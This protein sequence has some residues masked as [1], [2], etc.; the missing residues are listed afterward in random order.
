[1]NYSTARGNVSTLFAVEINFSSCGTPISIQ[2]TQTGV[3]VR[4]Q[5]VRKAEKND[6]KGEN[7]SESLVKRG[8]N[9]YNKED[10]IA[11][12]SVEALR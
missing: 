6:A 5:S 11:F 1:M 10:K 3:S 4:L 12:N 8:A 7:I 2:I 9:V